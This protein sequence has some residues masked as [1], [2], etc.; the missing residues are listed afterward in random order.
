MV[1]VLNQAAYQVKGFR[2]FD[3]VL[4]QGIECFIFGRRSSGMFDVR[5]LNGTKVNDSVSFKKL[6]LIE[7]RKSILIQ[8]RKDG[9]SS[10]I[11]R[12][13]FPCQVLS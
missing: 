13:G 9:N 10:H 12:N 3:K 4:F 5:M 8:K 11:L 6:T 2:L 1:Y 7:K